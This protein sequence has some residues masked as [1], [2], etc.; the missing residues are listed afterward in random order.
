[1][2]TIRKGYYSVIDKMESIDLSKARHQLITLPALWLCV[3]FVAGWTGKM[4]IADAVGLTPAEIHKRDI[5]ML[6]KQGGER[7]TAI[8]SV[9][10]KVDGLAYE[11][12]VNWAF[13]TL[14]KA[15]TALAEHMAEFDHTA[16]NWERQRRELEN[17][18]KLANDYKLC[19]LS[20]SGD[21]V[22]IQRQLLQ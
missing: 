13:E 4:W 12:R 19:V 7:D 8:K 17:R 5:D 16:P 10:T 20:R 3:I 9:G 11:L 15:E 22:V 21:C 2:Q 14:N 18:V 6:L 1:M